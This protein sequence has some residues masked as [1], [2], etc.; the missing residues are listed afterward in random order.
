MCF[1]KHLDGNLPG[2]FVK[3]VHN[4]CDDLKKKHYNTKVSKKKER[5]RER[6]GRESNFEIVPREK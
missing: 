5:E 1:R 3:S 2:L 4:L 6:I